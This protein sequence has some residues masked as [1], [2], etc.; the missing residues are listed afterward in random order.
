MTNSSNSVKIR[1]SNFELCR[2]AC[3]FYIV[4]FHLFIHNKDVT[5]GLYY[6]RAL[7]T[8][9][10]IGVPVFVIISG[11]FGIKR[12]VR[13]FLNI[14]SQVLFY[15]ICVTLVCVFVFDEPVS[16]GNLLSIIF[17]FTKSQYW[18]V[19]AYLLLY[20]LSPYINKFLKS[21]TF[22]EEVTYLI[23][24]TLL[25][26]YMGGIMKESDCGNRS[27]ILFVYLYSIGSFIKKCLDIKEQNCS[28]V[29]KKIG[30]GHFVYH[31][32]SI[33]SLWYYCSSILCCHFI[34]PHCNSQRH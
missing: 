24:L 10:K 17:P 30:G 9:F 33:Q 6:T 18:F 11:Y 4:V 34:S 3:M 14:I 23:V 25:V 29:N 27:V 26:G 2:L 21:I 13:G 22:Q 19:K 7:T 5:G 12:S 8:I 32:S 16:Q 15:S 1:A 20:I 28:L 31:K